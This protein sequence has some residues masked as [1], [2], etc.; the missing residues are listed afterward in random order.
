MGNL[1]THHVDL[2]RE[3]KDPEFSQLI[4]DVLRDGKDAGEIKKY[5]SRENTGERG[6][7]PV[8]LGMEFTH[9]TLG[10]Q[11]DAR[12]SDLEHLLPESIH[13]VESVHQN[14]PMPETLHIVETILP[15]IERLKAQK[16]GYEGAIAERKRRL[17]GPVKR[18]FSDVAEFNPTSF[19]LASEKT[20]DSI[21]ESY[22]LVE[23]ELSIVLPQEEVLNQTLENHR[24]ARNH[25]FK[26]LFS[27]NEALEKVEDKASE[28][29]LALRQFVLKFISE[30]DFREIV[31][32]SD[33]LK[34]ILNKCLNE[35]L[36]QQANKEIIEAWSEQASYTLENLSLATREILEAEIKKYDFILDFLDAFEVE[37]EVIEVNKIGG[38][39]VEKV[40]SSSP[41]GR[42]AEIFGPVP[43]H[44]LTHGYK[45]LSDGVEKAG[46]EKKR[47]KTGIRI[48]KDAIGI[49]KKKQ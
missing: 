6:E 25:D 35:I 22:W 48:I 39:E 17:I 12:I 21:G 24:Q 18:I 31:E 45:P 37:K 16:E 43:S 14:N 47:A 2:Q 11:T 1:Q 34:G 26:E 3:S 38:L 29:G 9:D 27:Q 7:V 46:R 23:G 49:F 13:L 32:K 28:I 20:I 10:V 30:Q 41:I 44:H 4:E 42:E 5:L 36:V 8:H 40:K 33:N 15:E 19:G